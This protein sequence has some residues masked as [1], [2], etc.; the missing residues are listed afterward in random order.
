MLHTSLLPK[1]TIALVLP[2]W[3]AAPA[4]A[5]SPTGLSARLDRLEKAVARAQSAVQVAQLYNQPQYEQPPANVPGGEN[6]GYGGQDAA[7]LDV[8]VDRLENEMRTL[9]GQIQQMQFDIHRLDDQL[10]KFQ[11]DVDFRFQDIGHGGAPARAGQHHSENDVPTA[12]PSA[13]PIDQS[14]TTFG[15]PGPGTRSD[16]AFNPA[17]NPNAPGAP[18]VLGTLRSDGGSQDSAGEPAVIAAP[19]AAGAPPLPQGPI[20]PANRDPNAPLELPSAPHMS[21]G[22]VYAATPP[23]AV[24]PSAPAALP[25]TSLG[26]AIPGTAPS[27]GTSTP[28]EGTRLAALP[29]STTPR[30]DFDAAAAALKGEQYATAEKGFKAFIDKYPKDKLLPD[31]VFYLGETYF[32]RN[33]YREAAEQYLK[34]SANY[35]TTIKAPDSLL[36]LGESLDKL[37]AKEQAC[38]AFAEVGRKY[39]RASPGLR[40]AAHR[41]AKHAQ[42]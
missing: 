39:P 10:H 26:Q 19:A 38:A 31:A 3:F 25:P 8:R 37:G 15:A 41:E 23:S 32:L 33:R 34:I 11:Q 36:R 14:A 17:A 13:S 40:A 35:S 7:A 16:D 18:R 22:P 12:P 27:G 20:E 2:L 21:S 24:T 42:C 9:N 1:W 30:E 4:A 28:P 29:P 6:G 5:D